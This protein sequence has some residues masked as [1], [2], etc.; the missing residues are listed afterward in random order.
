MENKGISEKEKGKRKNIYV[1]MKLHPSSAAVREK[2]AGDRPR[3][4]TFPILT[5]SH[6]MGGALG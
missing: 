6:V 3:Q 2:L 1:Y 4:C 5:T